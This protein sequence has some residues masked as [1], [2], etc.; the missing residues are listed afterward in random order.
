[1]SEAGT[2]SGEVRQAREAVLAAHDLWWVFLLT[3]SAWVLFSI[4]VLRFDIT[5]AATISIL[6]GCIM[7]T[8]AV[9]EAISAFAAAG[10]PRAG[11]TLLALACVVIGVVAFAQPGGTFR[12]LA[13]VISFYLVIKGTVT[14]IVSLAGGRDVDLWWLTLITGMVEVALGFWAAG[15]WGHG[16]ALLLA[17][18]GITALMRGIGELVFAFSLRKAG[19]AT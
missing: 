5:S 4:V 14:V 9:V 6:F 12:A 18:I 7:L 19:G 3:G 2:Y 16:A 1:M 17:W 8:A 15:Y 11:H 10:W 13:G